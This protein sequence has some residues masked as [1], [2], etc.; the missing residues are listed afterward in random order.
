MISRR[1]R[2]E[3]LRRDGHTCRYCGATPPDVK[4]TVDHV[5]P[6]ALGGTDEPTNLVSACAECNAGK[7]SS[8]PDA[9]IVA[10][11]ADDALRWAAA[12]RAAAA[13]QEG[14]SAQREAYVNSFD[15]AWHDWTYTDTGEPIE[16]PEA[17]PDSIARFYDLGLEFERL[18]NSLQIAMRHRTRGQHGAFRYMCG[19]C[20]GVIDERQQIAR[21]LIARDEGGPA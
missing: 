16:R 2:Y 21:D 10:N 7:A 15:Q 5:V 9:A 3:I 19:I 13:I 14:Q 20:W 18:I 6:V 12:M 1:L 8:S 4:L 17:W 11:V